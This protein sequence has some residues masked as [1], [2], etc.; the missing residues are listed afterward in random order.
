[1]NH[2][3]LGVIGPGSH[4]KKRIEPILEKNN[5]VKRKIVE[6][7]TGSEHFKSL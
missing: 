3:S 7:A 4:F 5:F 6:S 2:H 1:M